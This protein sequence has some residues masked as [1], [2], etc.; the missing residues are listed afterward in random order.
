VSYSLREALAAFRRAPMLVALSVI[1]ISLSLF[2]V[3]LFG[4]AAHNIRLA[5]E[6]V[7]S[8][9]EVVGYLRDD[10]L[11]AQVQSARAE[12]LAMPEVMD[13]IHVSKTEALAAAV[14]DLEE[15]REIYAELDANPLPASIEVRLNPGHRNP[16]AVERVAQR[17]A[18]MP[19]IEDVRFGREWLDRIFSLR[20]IAA[21]GAGILGG[22]FA[23]VATIII[24][25]AVRIAV[26]ARRDEISI[27]RLVG[28]TNAFIRRPF[29]LEGVFTGLVGGALAVG[30]TYLAYVAIDRSLIGIDW[31]P[32]AWAALAV[33]AGV[34]LGFLSSLVAVRRHLRA[35]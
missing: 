24:A 5:I 28:A 31:I 8:R 29:I 11:D 4:L 35:V 23:L 6:T 18:A 3:G 19:F 21:G 12:L 17:L 14:R 13:I 34:L 2:V 7:E 15:F 30:F 1:S 20:R 10:V 27:M 33:V 26:F 32:A 25:T 22:A 9:V 16:E